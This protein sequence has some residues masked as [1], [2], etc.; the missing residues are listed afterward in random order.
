MAI[1]RDHSLDSWNDFSREMLRDEGW[2]NWDGS[3]SLWNQGESRNWARQLR[4]GSMGRSPDYTDHRDFSVT[5]EDELHHTAQRDYDRI[6]HDTGRSPKNYHR[7][8]S[9]V[10]EDIH[11]RLNHHGGIDARDVRVSITDGEVILEGTVKRWSEKRL[12]E[13]VVE[14]VKGVRD[15]QNR[16]KASESRRRRGVIFVPKKE[17]DDPG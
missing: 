2:T 9:L 16:I 7:P 12:I 14:M 1:N 5:H 4:H 11:R 3:H 15:I 8:D 13:D 17:A 10:E 6:P